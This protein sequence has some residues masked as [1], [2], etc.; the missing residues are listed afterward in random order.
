MRKEFSIDTKV[1]LFINGKDSDL[2]VDVY[3]NLTSFDVRTFDIVNTLFAVKFIDVYE[4][5]RSLKGKETDFDS[6]VSRLADEL[7]IDIDL[8]GDILSDVAG[9]FFMIPSKIMNVIYSSKR[10]QSYFIEKLKENG[11]DIDLS[12]LEDILKKLKFKEIKDITKFSEIADS[13]RIS[14]D[15]LLDKLDKA[16]DFE[17]QINISSSDYTGNSNMSIMFLVKRVNIDLSAGKSIID[18][19]V[20]SLDKDVVGDVI[21]TEFLVEFSI[22]NKNTEEFLPV[23]LG[24]AVD[25]ELKQQVLAIYDD[26]S[27]LYDVID[28]IAD[29]VGKSSEEIKTI[30][31]D[32]NDDKYDIEKRFEHR[33]IRAP[34]V[35]YELDNVNI[36]TK[37]KKVIFDILVLSP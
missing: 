21:L 4:I 3:F 6:W 12:D 28:I 9:R 27:E 25:K 32:L 5:E 18:V 13:L 20:I 34:I 29:K 35:R 36:D 31:D 15:E 19:D 17:D 14:I 11:K 16:N 24:V 37:E 23:V 7:K 10:M 22:D 30:L 33:K 1:P 26:I 8:L 2:L